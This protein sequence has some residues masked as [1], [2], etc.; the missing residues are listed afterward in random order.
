MSDQD[1]SDNRQ[2]PSVTDMS[3]QSSPSMANE[4]LI[5]DMRKQLFALQSENFALKRSLPKMIDTNGKDLTT[6]IQGLYNRLALREQESE[7]WENKYA[8]AKQELARFKDKMAQELEV[9]EKQITMLKDHARLLEEENAML[10]EQA[11]N[12]HS[13]IYHLEKVVGSSTPLSDYSDRIEPEP[14]TEVNVNHDDS[15]IT[16]FRVC[17]QVCI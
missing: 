17:L 10:K 6:K 5:A 8:E 16:S 1:S 15:P 12:D 9:R 7:R 2:S 3:P 13:R 14:E 4:S 11:E